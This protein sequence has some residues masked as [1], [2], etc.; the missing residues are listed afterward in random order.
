[1]PT[2]FSG[3]SRSIPGD[4]P[5]ARLESP[6]LND[7]GMATFSP[8]GSRLVVTTNQPPCVHIWDLRAVRSQ[9][10]EMGL[11]WDQPPYPAAPPI[12]ADLHM[13]RHDER[14]AEAEALCSQGQ[15]EKGAAAYQQAFTAGVLVNP[16]MLFENALLRLAVNDVAGYQATRTLMLEMLRDHNTVQWMEFTAHA[17]VLAPIGEAER[18]QALR[19]AASRDSFLRTRWSDLVTGLALYRTLQFSEADIRLKRSLEVEP[20]W[21]FRVLTWLVLAMADHQIGR[22]FDARSWLDRAVNGW[23]QLAAAPRPAWRNGSRH[24]SAAGFGASRR[25]SSPAARRSPFIAT[26]SLQESPR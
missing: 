12:R 17:F 5:L 19:L 15:W 6:D 1:M 9:L 22:D 3:W 25:S 8:D 7:T 18:E 4:A 2:K 21:D 10:A 11:D 16:W 24:S 14:V 20:E 13:I 23:V 26:R